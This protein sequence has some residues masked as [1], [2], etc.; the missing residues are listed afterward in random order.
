MNDTMN[1]TLESLVQKT[2]FNIVAKINKESNEDRKKYFNL[3]EKALGVLANDGVY[4]YCIFVKYKEGENYFLE[5]L[6]GLIN[7]IFGEES[8]N[9]NGSKEN[10]IIFNKDNAEIYFRELSKNLYKLLFLKQVLERVLIYARYH[11]KALSD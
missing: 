1:D 4:A 5:P 11:A 3:I 6:E 2:A 8:I 9:S 10:I 7:E